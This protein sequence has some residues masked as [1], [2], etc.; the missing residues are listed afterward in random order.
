MNM[1]RTLWRGAIFGACFL[2]ISPFAF[3]DRDHDRA[4]QLTQDK[5]IL[6]LETIL[7]KARDQDFHRVLEVEL[8]K[9]HGRLVYELEML[10]ANGRVWELRFDATTGR[11]MEKE[12]EE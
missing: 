8:E 5:V 7:E 10:D 3:A 9:K 12:V 1:A 2:T 6:P 4:W 11:L